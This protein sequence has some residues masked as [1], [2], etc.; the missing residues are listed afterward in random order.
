MDLFRPDQPGKVADIIGQEG[1]IS[2]T[3]FDRD[4][5]LSTIRSS[6]LIW[7]TTCQAPDRA[8]PVQDL[9][10]ELDSAGMVTST[11]SFQGLAACRTPGPIFGGDFG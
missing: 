9:P 10:I 1:V 6:I 8:I 5:W 4:E 11:S 3:F 2:G 7:E